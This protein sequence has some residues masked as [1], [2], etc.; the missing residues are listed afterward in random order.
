[1][2]SKLNMKKGGDRPEQLARCYRAI[3]VQPKRNLFKKKVKE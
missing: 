2:R 3:L 1:M